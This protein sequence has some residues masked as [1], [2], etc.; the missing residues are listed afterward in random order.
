MQGIEACIREDKAPGKALLE[1]WRK[2]ADE[3]AK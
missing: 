1:I 3:K 2:I